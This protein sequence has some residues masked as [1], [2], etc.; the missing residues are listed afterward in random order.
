MKAQDIANKKCLKVKIALLGGRDTIENTRA[1]ADKLGWNFFTKLEG[2]GKPHFPDLINIQKE[3][4][5]LSQTTDPND[6]NSMLHFALITA[7]LHSM[8]ERQKTAKP[9]L[10][11]TVAPKQKLISFNELRKVINTL[12]KFSKS[13]QLGLDEEFSVS[14]VPLSNNS[15]TA[16]RPEDFEF[17]LK[18]GGALF[19]TYKMKDRIEMEKHNPQL[20]EKIFNGSV[21]DLVSSYKTGFFARFS[22]SKKEIKEREKI[23]QK[24]KELFGIE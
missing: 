4:D 11:L 21:K 6:K 13:F 18:Y 8:K 3:Y 17:I 20:T 2:Y 23:K 15:L 19:I 10:R 14:D 24:F 7:A 12:Q 16:K 1:Y 9:I 22:A 5:R